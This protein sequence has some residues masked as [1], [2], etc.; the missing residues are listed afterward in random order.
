MGWISSVGCSVSQHSQ[1]GRVMRASN[2]P[3]EP[4][5]LLFNQVNGTKVSV[6]VIWINKNAHTP[7]IVDVLTCYIK[8]KH[9]SVSHLTLLVLNL[10]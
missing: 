5:G 9:P 10:F 8:I 2:S 6:K 7:N 3:R 4:T 1:E